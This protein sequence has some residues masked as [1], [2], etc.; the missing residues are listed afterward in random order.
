VG[1]N[2]PLGTKTFGPTS[3]GIFTKDLLQVHFFLLGTSWN[4]YYFNCCSFELAIWA[5]PLPHDG[6][7]DA[8]DMFHK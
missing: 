1:L 6:L 8:N 4:I 2:L 5:N 7:F 3:W